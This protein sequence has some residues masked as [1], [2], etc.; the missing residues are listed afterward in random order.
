MYE[1]E[2]FNQSYTITDPQLAEISRLGK[3][4]LKDP[5]TMHLLWNKF[6]NQNKIALFLGVNRSSI[7]RRFKEY[8][9]Q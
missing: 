7:N 6:K 9:I 2:L 1:E 3:S 4:A 8:N 5:K